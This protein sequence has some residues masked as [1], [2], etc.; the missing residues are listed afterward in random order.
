[1]TATIAALYEY[2][3]WANE[4]V[5]EKARDLGHAELTRRFSE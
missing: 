4:R 2:G 3:E 5:L 1:M